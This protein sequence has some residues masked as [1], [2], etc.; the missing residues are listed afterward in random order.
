MIEFAKKIIGGGRPCRAIKNKRNKGLTN[1]YLDKGILLWR[2][3]A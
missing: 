3:E 1:Y 2:A